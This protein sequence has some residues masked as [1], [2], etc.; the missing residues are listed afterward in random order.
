MIRVEP[1][2][3]V[4]PLFSG[5][6]LNFDK[7]PE[8][9]GSG[10]PFMS[11]G[12]QSKQDAL[13]ADKERLRSAKNPSVAAGVGRGL[14]KSSRMEQ[15][16]QFEVGEF[17]N[18]ETGRLEVEV[19][20]NIMRPRKRRGRDAN[21][22]AA[23]FQDASNFFQLPPG[24]LGMK[25]LHQLIAVN[26]INRIG[27]AR[28]M[29]AVGNGHAE[30]RGYILSPGNFGRNVD[31]YDFAKMRAHGMGEAAIAGAYFN[32]G[33][34]SIHEF[35]DQRELLAKSPFPP[36]RAGLLQQLRVVR[37]AQKHFV[38][39][40]AV[41]GQPVWSIRRAK[42]GSQFLFNEIVPIQF[43]GRSHFAV[44]NGVQQWSWHSW[45]IISYHR[46]AK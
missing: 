39:K 15:A 20:R 37:R 30:I 23:G 43:F 7:G 5:H 33:C 2:S 9:Q 28:D 42:A 14:A 32:E 26:D 12:W 6:H 29:D 35:S 22:F 11:V 36:F 46:G 8:A 17:L 44:A 24:I 41:Q 3:P 34:F 27:F 38:I 31:T 19:I 4:G 45:N 18:M 21:V 10:N 1:P 13:N 40:A 25:V 16:N